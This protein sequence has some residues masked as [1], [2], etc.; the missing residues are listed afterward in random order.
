MSKQNQNEEIDKILGDVYSSNNRWDLENRRH[1]RKNT[2][3]LSFEQEEDEPVYEQ[4]VA[5]PVSADV[6]DVTIENTAFEKTTEPKTVAEELAVQEEPTAEAVAEDDFVQEAL[7]D[8]PMPV[9]SDPTEA[10]SVESFLNDL[11]AENEATPEMQEEDVRVFGEEPKAEVP[12]DGSTRVLNVPLET[13]KTEVIELT[14]DGEENE[15]DEEDEEDQKGKYSEAMGCLKSII[16]VLVVLAVS[17]VLAFFIYKAVVDVTGIGRSTMNID[18]EIPE[19]ASTQEIAELL[20]AEGL[21]EEP[22]YFRAYCRLVHADGT[23]HPGVHTLSA[24]MGY[25]GLVSHLKELEERETVTVTIPEGSTIDVIANLMEENGVCTARQFYTALV[26]FSYE[27]YDFIS[28]ISAK[29]REQRVYLLEGYLFPDTYEF[30][31]DGAPETAIR[32]MLDN[33]E[34]RVG[35]DLLAQI[36]ADESLDKYIIMASIVQMEAGKA[37]DMPRVMRVLK[38]RLDSDSAEFAYL[39]MDSTGD[40]LANLMQTNGVQIVDTAYD[41]YEREGLPVG[42]ICNPGMDAINAVF[43]PS[44]EED[45]I[46]CYFFASIVETGE[47][48]FFETFEEHEAY[49]IEH[50]IGTYG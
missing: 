33:F 2:A 15:E 16:Y 28:A 4:P 43:N 38:N 3:Y 18:V 26:S 36:P 6:E 23:F 47:T 42:A 46:D 25:D 17:S 37:E 7:P 40:Y 8:I 19:G 29:E 50:G 13:E 45:I 49:C 5:E 35:P 20:K 14:S 24:N 12:A 1:E 48:A 21:I 22:F 34:K 9:G 10:F 31:V 39:R 32:T 44:T 11:V 27:D 41:T 30:Y